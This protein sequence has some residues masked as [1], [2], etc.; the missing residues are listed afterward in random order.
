[1]KKILFNFLYWGK[2]STGIYQITI[3]LLKELVNFLSDEYELFCL[4][5]FYEDI[6][7]DKLKIIKE[8]FKRIKL[9]PKIFQTQFYLKNRVK[10][11]KP[12]L[13]FNFFHSGYLLSNKT[14]QISIIHDLIPLS[15][16]KGNLINYLYFRFFL[17][18]LINNCKYILTPSNATK[19]DIIDIFKIPEEKI[20]VVYWGVDKERFKKLNIQKENFYLIVNATFPYKNVDYIIKLWRKFNIKDR[21]IIIGY[22]PKYIKYHNYLKELTKKLSLEDKITFYKEVSDEKLIELYN[23]A[24]ALISPSLKEGFG[25]PP[26]EALSCGTPVILSNIPVYKEIY[27]DI[28]IFFDLDN[29]EN[30]KEALEKVENLNQE[31]FNYK[32]EEFLKKFDWQKTA[33]EIYKIIKDC[34]NEKNIN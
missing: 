3:N 13:I 16:F 24:K 30:F 33:E 2:K 19:N 18:T 12:G 20:K 10:K 21:L 15:I 7:I 8:E 9:I 31:E 22:H 26:L 5:N 14:P 29:E 6:K 4:T 28:A 23:K 25:L 17:K 32:R 27:N 1:M 34:L 11:I